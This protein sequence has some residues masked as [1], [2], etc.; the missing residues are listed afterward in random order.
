MVL[1]EFSC[2]EMTRVLTSSFQSS[3]DHAGVCRRESGEGRPYFRQIIWTWLAQVVELLLHILSMYMIMLKTVDVGL[4][5]MLWNSPRVRMWSRPST[6]SSP[7]RKCR[8]GMGDDLLSFRK[9][10]KTFLWNISRDFKLVG[11]IGREGSPETSTGREHVLQRCTCTAGD[12]RHRKEKAGP[13]NAKS[14]FLH[15]IMFWW[16]F[17][18]Q[19]ICSDRLQPT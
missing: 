16:T 19:G 4:L 15:L 1:R 7:R 9:P 12:R 18:G 14:E 10:L 5:H 13:S 8:A 17:S 2:Q 3:L 6:G 11:R